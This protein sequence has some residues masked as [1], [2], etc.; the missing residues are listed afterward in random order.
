MCECGERNRET[1]FAF[2]CACFDEFTHIWK[3]WETLIRVLFISS[4]LW[5]VKMVYMTH[6]LIYILFFTDCIS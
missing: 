5:I 2:I 1:C 4:S 6:V 3:G